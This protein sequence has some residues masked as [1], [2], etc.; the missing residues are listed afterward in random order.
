MLLPPRERDLIG[1]CQFRAW[2]EKTT[3]KI[4]A[5]DNLLVL[6]TAV[7]DAVQQ[8]VGRAAMM[9]LMVSRAQPS[10]HSNH[11]GKDPEGQRS[12]GAH[13]RSQSHPTA[14]L[15][16]TQMFGQQGSYPE[17]CSSGGG[18]S[19][20][21]DESGEPATVDREHRWLPGASRALVEPRERSSLSGGRGLD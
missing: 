10:P 13:S 11:R 17:L 12:Q 18:C 19:V 9:T 6:G 16:K 7:G 3:H 2:V 4:W 15:N 14:E 5:S 8:T 20:P 21:G 1:R